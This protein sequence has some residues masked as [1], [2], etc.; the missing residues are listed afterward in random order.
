VGLG[1]SFLGV[2]LHITFSL[3]LSLHMCIYIY[4]Y[5]QIYTSIYNIIRLPIGGFGAFGE[6]LVYYIIP[7]TKGDA[8]D[9]GV[10]TCAQ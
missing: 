3:S 8:T 4:I 10:L 1:R 7:Q 2:A 6:N 5:I 9:V